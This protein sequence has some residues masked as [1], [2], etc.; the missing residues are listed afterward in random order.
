MATQ[1]GN[2]LPGTVIDG[3]YRI[4]TVI[5]VGGMGTVCRAVQLSIDRTVAIKLLHPAYAQDSTQVERFQREARLA[6]A[7]GHDNICEVTDLGRDASGTPYLVMPLLK[8]RSLAD[9]LSDAGGIL[10][11]QRLGDIVSQTLS[12]LD[13]APADCKQP[14]PN[15]FQS[16]HPG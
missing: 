9:V 5:G 8:G 4:E 1:N 15:H 13:A 10:P 7:I 14:R 12:A 16:L 2:R 3:K 6:A 11:L